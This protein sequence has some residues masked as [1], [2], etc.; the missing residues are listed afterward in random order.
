MGSQTPPPTP[1]PLWQVRPV[2]F[3]APWTDPNG[4]EHIAERDFVLLELLDRDGEVLATATQSPEATIHLAR[5]LQ[6][7]AVHVIGSTVDDQ[8][9]KPGLRERFARI[10]AAYADDLT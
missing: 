8:G 6:D 4:V 9:R 1:S 5:A 10:N 3:G 7:T 2:P